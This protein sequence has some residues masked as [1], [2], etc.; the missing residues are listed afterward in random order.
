MGLEEIVNKIRNITDRQVISFMDVGWESFW[1][2]YKH[3][4]IDDQLKVI[5]DL[6]KKGI[7]IEV[8]NDPFIQLKDNSKL[9]IETFKYNEGE[10]LTVPN[11]CKQI[12]I[13]G[14]FKRVLAKEATFDIIR[15]YFSNK[16]TEIQ[17]KFKKK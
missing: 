7:T 6:L 13:Y 17:E 14:W 12:F 1:Y 15:L 3:S 16:D 5:D 8:V 2:P 10:L 11:D 4:N 9:N